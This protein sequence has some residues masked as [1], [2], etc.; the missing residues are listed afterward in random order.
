MRQWL[1]SVH[2]IMLRNNKLTLLNCH[3]EYTATSPDPE[4]RRAEIEKGVIVQTWM[5]D[6]HPSSEEQKS[7]EEA[8][9][10]DDHK[11]SCPIC[12]KAFEA[13]VEVCSSRNQTCGHTFHK[14]CI[15]NWL[16][17]QNRCPAC[18]EEYLSSTGPSLS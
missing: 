2:I 11:N 5:E 18:N 6:V 12:Q 13:G 16:Q 10:A 17:Y 4:K 1:S 3:N 9:G 8:S 14:T 15:F 7:D